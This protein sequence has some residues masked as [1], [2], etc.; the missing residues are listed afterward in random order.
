MHYHFIAEPMRD[1]T[2]KLLGVEINARFTS[3]TVHPLHP[4]FIISAWDS[5]QK[6]N[7]MLEQIRLI[8]EKRDWFERNS[9][10]CTLNLIDEMALL[11]IGDP[12]IKSA[13]H[14]LPFIALEL[15]E[16]FLSNTVC[17]NNLLI[18]SL[19]D[20][21]NALWLGDLGSG[22]VGASPLVCGHFDV[23][24]LDRGFFLEQ[25]EKPMFPVLIKNIREYCD[26]VVV[27]GGDDAWLSDALSNAGIWAVQG[28]IFPSVAFNDIEALLPVKIFH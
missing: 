22:S 13:L 6:R 16:R 11:A 15:S 28:G 19:R 14:A 9:L 4:D 17:L 7:F 10:I 24:K 18:N 3:D 27:K 25:V 20:G 21:P 5:E 2:D 23:V 1:T 8:A 26:R 12:A